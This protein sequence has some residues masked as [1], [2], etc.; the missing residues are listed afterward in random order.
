MYLK[1][2][3]PLRSIIVAL[4]S[5]VVFPAASAFPAAAPAAGTWSFGSGSVHVQPS[6][7]VPISAEKAEFPSVSAAAAAARLL[8]SAAAA[9]AGVNPGERISRHEFTLPMLI[10]RSSVLSVIAATTPTRSGT[11]S[12]SGKSSHAFPGAA[13]ERRKSNT[14]GNCTRHGTRWETPLPRSMTGDTS[15]CAST[16]ARRSFSEWSSFRPSSNSGCERT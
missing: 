13:I 15:Q 6:P 12:R 7:S 3:V 10:G 4:P 14:T 2:R 5:D 16:D 9:A 8:G 1:A 11:V